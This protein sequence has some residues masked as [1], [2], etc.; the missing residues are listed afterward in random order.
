MTFVQISEVVMALASLD[1]HK[2]LFCD[3]LIQSQQFIV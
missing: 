1:G 3:R 2:I